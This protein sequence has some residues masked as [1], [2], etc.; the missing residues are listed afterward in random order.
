MLPRPSFLSHLFGLPSVYHELVF[1]SPIYPALIA[2]SEAE[3]GGQTLVEGHSGRMSE[4]II[5]I[6]T[7]FFV[8]T[9]K[10]AICEFFGARFRTWENKQAA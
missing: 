9:Q 5:F 2:A 7:N 10:S 1:A 4:K 8:L 3:T 6:A